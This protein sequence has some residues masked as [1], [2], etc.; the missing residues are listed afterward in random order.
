MR[1]PVSIRARFLPPTR[2]T[3]AAFGATRVDRHRHAD[4]TY[5]ALLPFRLMYYVARGGYARLYA[6]NVLSRRSARW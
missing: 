2:A 5:V 1:A 3:G 6:V 4:V